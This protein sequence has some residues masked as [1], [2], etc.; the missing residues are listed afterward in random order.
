[1][2]PARPMM[3]NS[4]GRFIL[5]GCIIVAVEIWELKSPGRTKHILLFHIVIR[6]RNSTKKNVSIYGTPNPGNISTREPRSGVVGLKLSSV[7]NGSKNRVKTM[8][9]PEPTRTLYNL[10]NLHDLKTLA[11]GGAYETNCPVT[12][13][14]HQDL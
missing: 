14:L 5:W 2:G 9:P 8:S 12:T 3:C 13:I 10:T 6:L 1:M 4:V 7:A 11:V